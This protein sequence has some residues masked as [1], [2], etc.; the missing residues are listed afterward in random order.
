[1]GALPKRSPHL[2]HQYSRQKPAPAP[3][4][5]HP[6][7][8]FRSL[9]AFDPAT[10]TFRH[11]D[12]AGGGSANAAPARALAAALAPAL[13]ASPPSL[14]TAPRTP[15]QVGGNDC[16]IHVIVNARAVAGGVVGGGGWAAADAA[17]VE[18]AP[19]VRTERAR[20]RAEILGG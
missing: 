11:Y 12:S 14:S 9:L 6:T 8:S 10:L 5:R 20:L 2:I 18:S 7:P 19:L 16:G 17:V 13:G 4:P 3:I 1:M 15:Q